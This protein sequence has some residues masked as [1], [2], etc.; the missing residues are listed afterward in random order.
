[1]ASRERFE[2]VFRESLNRYNLYDDD[3]I[4][5]DEGT[6]LLH[7]CYTLDTGPQENLGNETDYDYDDQTSPCVL[8]PIPILPISENSDNHF[9]LHVHLVLRASCSHT[10]HL[11][12]QKKISSRRVENNQTRE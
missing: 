1:M 6:A 3:E 7:P 12:K 10:S 8:R 4:T 2:A 9:L 5:Q 11:T